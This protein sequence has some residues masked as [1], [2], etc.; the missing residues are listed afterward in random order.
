MSKR[1]YAAIEHSVGE[2]FNISVVPE[3]LRY[4]EGAVDKHLGL[5]SRFS[6]EYWGRSDVV[7]W[8][9]EKIERCFRMVALIAKK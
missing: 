9:G 4:L 5:L 8:A 1:D 2:V 3:K 6:E 7:G